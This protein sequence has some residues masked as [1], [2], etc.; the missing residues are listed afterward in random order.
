MPMTMAEYDVKIDYLGDSYTHFTNAAT[1]PYTYTETG[2]VYVLN[3]IRA[4][5]CS[6][7]YYHEIRNDG[8]V[9][10]IVLID[11]VNDS[12]FMPNLALKNVIAAK[13]SAGEYYY[14]FDFFNYLKLQK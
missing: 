9:G 11:L 4:E 1:G 5:L 7:G 14:Y 13:D 2:N 12:P 8:S 6:D 10:A 3:S